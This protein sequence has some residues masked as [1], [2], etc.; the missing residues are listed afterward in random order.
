MKIGYLMQ[1]GEE[2][3]RPPYNGPANHV[4]QVVQAL[5]D[6]GHDVR[7]LVRL[8]EEF[9]LTEDLE[10]FR[11]VEADGQRAAAK[12]ARLFES[13]VRRAQR[14]LRLPY[15]AYYESRHFAQ[16]CQQELGGCEV[17]LERMSWMTYGGW[18]AARRQRVPLVLE[19][20]GDPLIDLRAKDELP[21]G[22]Q[23]RISLSITGKALRSADRLIATG[24]GWRQNL[25]QDWQVRPERVTTIENG[26]TLVDLLAR[27]QLR[28]FQDGANPDQPLTLV[29]LGG[30]YAWHGLDILLQALA[31]AREQQLEFCLLLIGSGAE[32][33]ATRQR[34]SQLGLNERVQ[35]LGQLSDRE[36]AVHLAHADIGF[37]P[38]CG[39][40]EY[41]GLKLFDYKAAGLPTIASGVGSQ[42]A[43]LKHRVTGLIVPPCDPTALAQAILE[44]AANPQL[45]RE[46]GRRARLEAESQHRWAHTAQK[47]ERVLQEALAA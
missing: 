17:F 43:A 23:Y 20:N 6:L 1:K 47:I 37:S 36:Y 16:V 10:H 8:D 44:L 40:S 46:M 9:W 30:F 32:E 2:I 19:Y 31:A 25:I 45:R 15:L 21:R 38:Y 22:L 29:H 5:Q 34:A 39:R 33:S 11:Q 28:A 26:T 42:P 41:S 14:E 24:D 3:R 35:F 27:S 12:A 7:V 13:A 4:R 18:L